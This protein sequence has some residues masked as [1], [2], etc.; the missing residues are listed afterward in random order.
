MLD[1]ATA[2]RLGWVLQHLGFS[3]EELEALAVFPV[4]GY[5]SLD[6]TGPRVGPCDSHWMIQENLPGRT[7]PRCQSGI[8]RGQSHLRPPSLE[9]D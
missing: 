3:P 2:K 5:R 7:A 1:G 8:L 4:R 9:T 6:P